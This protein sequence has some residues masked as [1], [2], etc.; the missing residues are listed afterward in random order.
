MGFPARRR[1][2]VE[3]LPLSLSFLFF[4]L[5]SVSFFVFFLFLLF[6][7]RRKT[8][9]YWISKRYMR[10]VALF[11][12]FSRLGRVTCNRSQHS[13]I[14][15]SF[16]LIDKRAKTLYRY[17]SANLGALR[18]LLSRVARRWI[19]RYVIDANYFCHW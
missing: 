13:I 14:S 7:I 8:N 16:I 18:C 17:L 4:F 3:F 12:D 19:P 5:S 11:L 6:P 10:R 1:K 9:D 2:S 15:G